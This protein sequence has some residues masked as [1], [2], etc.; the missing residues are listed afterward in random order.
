MRVDSF[1]LSASN[2]PER[3]F[4]KWGSP[5]R[6]SEANRVPSDVSAVEG[7]KPLFSKHCEATPKRLSVATR[8]RVQD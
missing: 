6:S 5:L 7:Q 3:E 4:L 8:D 2:N 1:K